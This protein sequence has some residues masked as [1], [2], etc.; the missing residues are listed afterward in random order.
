M[1]STGPV[2]MGPTS[3][4][5]PDRFASGNESQLPPARG[6]WGA[7]QRSSDRPAFRSSI[8]PTRGRRAVGG[9]HPPLTNAPAQ[10]PVRRLDCQPVTSPYKLKRWQPPFRARGRRIDE[11][12]KDNMVL[13]LSVLLFA[14][15]GQGV[16][17]QDET[18]ASKASLERIVADIADFEVSTAVKPPRKLT[19]SG[20]PVLRWNY[21]SRNLDDAALFV[22]LGKDRPEVVTT[23]MSYHD[24]AGNPRRA[25]EF[26]S[27]S[28]EPLDAVQNGNRVW[29]PE[30][31]G[32]TWRNLPKA[33]LPARTLPERRR[34]M[35]DLAA[36]FQADVQSDKNRYELR[37]LSRPL[38][39]YQN[40][41]ADIL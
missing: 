11:F 31:P 37:L 15:P 8:P 5:V 32:F 20:E 38:Y 21:P 4:R 6:R 9:D 33:P 10:R 12:G 35:H 14:L 39:R 26:L 40:A 1:L 34:Q 23:V 41:K 19:L 36:K 29:Y 18:T 16:T 17:A 30:K 3:Q 28:Q 2:S 13:A 27:I 22:W 24:G 25:Y 7:T